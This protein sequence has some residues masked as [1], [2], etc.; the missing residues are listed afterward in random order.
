MKINIMCPKGKFGSLPYLANIMKQ[1][2]GN[3]V[4]ISG[5]TPNDYKPNYL[6][7]LID[8][9]ISSIIYRRKADVWWTDTPAMIPTSRHDIQ[10]ILQ[11]EKLFK[12]HYTVSKFNYNHYKQLG[13]PVEET[14]IPRPINPILFNYYTDYN[15][16]I[17]DIITIGKKDMCDRKNLTLQREIVLELNLKAVFVSDVFLY[18]RP[19]IVQYNF[20]SISDEFKAQLLT[21]SKFLLWTSFVEGFGMPVLEAMAVGTVPIYTDVPAHNEFAVGIPIKPIDKITTFCYGVKVIKYLIDK[22]DVIEAIKYAL[23]LS[24][25]EYINLQYECMNKAIEV[26]NDFISK[27]P[28]LLG[29]KRAN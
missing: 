16:T 26:Y 5:N 11:E 1:I 19:N 18:K 28:L 22:K 4:T 25:E 9:G 27:L 10:K 20:G 14:I 17:Y 7:L 8:E 13:I 12:K 15:N 24:R 21:Q 3:N 29:G 2:I 6:N 23:G